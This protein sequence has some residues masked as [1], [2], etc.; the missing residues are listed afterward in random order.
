MGGLVNTGHY[1]VTDPDIT[2]NEEGDFTP[3]IQPNASKFLCGGHHQTVTMTQKLLQRQ[4]SHVPYSVWKGSCMPNRRYNLE[5]ATSQPNLIDN[6]ILATILDRRWLNTGAKVDV[7]ISANFSQGEFLNMYW[8]G[9][10]CYNIGQDQCIAEGKYDQDNQSFTVDAKNQ[11]FQ[12]T[13]STPDYYYLK[14][15]SGSPEVE[16]K[17][18]WRYSSNYSYF[19][20]DT[21]FSEVCQI[22]KDNSPCVF[23][24]EDN[25]C[26]FIGPNG[27]EYVTPGVYQYN[28]NVFTEKKKGLKEN[29]H[30][31]SICLSAVCLTFISLVCIVL[32]CVLIRKPKYE[33]FG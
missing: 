30:Y 21:S 24:V 1:N 10:S 12:I 7:T 2:F 18:L 27:N 5:F 19:V 20:Q 14:I 17:V 15:R 4:T 9:Y 23:P 22:T 33:S 6:E 16:V 3:F 25:I 13:V 31:F 8:F 29:K 32:L 26:Y 11:Q 28:L